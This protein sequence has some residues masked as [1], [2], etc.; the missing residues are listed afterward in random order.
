MNVGLIGLGAMGTPMARHLLTRHQVTVF[1]MD[2][3]R[4]TALQE[5]GAL[6]AATIEAVAEASDVVV[7]MVA[8]PAQ[9]EAV[10]STLAPELSARHA[11]IVMSS[12]GAA[13]ALAAQEVAASAGARVVDAPVTGGVARAITGELK[14]LV[15]GDAADIDEVTSVLDLLGDIVV[16]GPKVGDGQAVKLVNQLLCSVHLAVAGEALTFAEAMGLDPEA[17]FLAIKDGAA[18]SWMLGDRG[19]RMLT[20]GE[21]EVRSAIDIFA[22]DSSLVLAAAE[23]AGARTPLLSVA[24]G[25]YAE[26]HEAGLGRQ[27]DSR[28]V[29]MFKNHVSEGTNA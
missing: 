12:V 26:A 3:T 17:V 6:P 9:L 25:L 14:I 13:A 16:C 4:A 22:K 11:I 21:V 24:A 1:D 23:H 20:D 19:P 10:M 7:I 29:E 18:G 5:H 15:S 28:I 27:D 8:T 2:A